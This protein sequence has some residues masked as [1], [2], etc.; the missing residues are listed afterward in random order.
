MLGMSGG[1]DFT[2]Q[3]SLSLMALCLLFVDILHEK[4][5]SVIAWVEKQ[6]LWMRWMLY[7]GLIWCT[8]MFGIYGIAYDTSQFIYFQF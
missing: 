2:L 5:I 1:P 7:L 8:I 6:E 4:K 3:V